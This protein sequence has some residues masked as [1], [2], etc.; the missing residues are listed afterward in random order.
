MISLSLFL[1]ELLLMPAPELEK[2]KQVIGL[3]QKESLLG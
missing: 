3:W 1:R 2:Q